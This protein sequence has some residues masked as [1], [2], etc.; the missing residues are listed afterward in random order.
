M[1]QEY[2][3]WH[4]RRTE[5]AIS[6][7]NKL[8]KSHRDLFVDE[9]S[10]TG[11]GEWQK[12]TSIEG[13][14][15]RFSGD[16][17]Y[18]V[19]SIEFKPGVHDNVKKI[20]FAQL[21]NL[22][23]VKIQHAAGVGGQKRHLN[24]INQY[25]LI[26][27][28][29]TALDQLAEVQDFTEP[30]PEAKHS[31]ADLK[32]N[33]ISRIP[34]AAKPSMGG[35]FRN[36]YTQAIQDEQQAAYEL[37]EPHILAAKQALEKVLSSFKE[38][39]YIT[40]Y[41]WVEEFISPYPS[42]YLYIPKNRELKEKVMTLLDSNLSIEPTPGSAQYRYD[43]VSYEFKVTDLE[44]LKNLPAKARISEIQLNIQRFLESHPV[45]KAD[46]NYTPGFF[47]SSNPLVL[48][49]IKAGLEKYANDGINELL[50]QEELTNEDVKNVEVNIRKIFTDNGADIKHNNLF[51]RLI[52]FIF[53]KGIF[54]IDTEVQMREMEQA[55][56]GATKAA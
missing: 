12:G 15:L 27:T 47:Q 46:E 41:L 14:S 32:A 2:V 40:S 45:P 30:K 6:Q 22:H 26:I 52:E 4:N 28:D 10:F 17:Q 36:Q 48:T 54:K 16:R 51:K 43:D 1:S 37:A 34:A 11:Q 19:I 44:V 8:L 35:V 56:I 18:P 13:S 49:T 50:A 33:Q 23:P 39:G 9:P 29:E 25:G 38:L 7:L 55:T 5:A 53:G 21:R 3:E 31:V 20:F 42:F 24:A